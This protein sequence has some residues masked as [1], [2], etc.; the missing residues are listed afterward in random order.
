[1]LNKY[2]EGYIP[3][4]FDGGTIPSAVINSITKVL[5]MLNDV[6]RLFSKLAS[7][8]ISHLA[9]TDTTSKS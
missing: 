6:T 3:K 4:E 1:M 2:V 5:N 8:M 7:E 9:K